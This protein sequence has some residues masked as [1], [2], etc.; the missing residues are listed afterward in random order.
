MRSACLKEF[1]VCFNTGT[2]EI[3]FTSVFVLSL[4]VSRFA[5][6]G[7]RRRQHFYIVIQRCLLS[8]ILLLSGNMPLW[9]YNEILRENNI[10]SLSLL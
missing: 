1:C 5:V 8:C 7:N 6:F 10:S 4:R 2:C 3:V 9:E